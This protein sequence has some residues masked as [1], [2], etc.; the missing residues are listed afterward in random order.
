[1]PS[2]SA[3]PTIRLLTFNTG[4]FR[5]RLGS[6]S[7]LDPIPHAAA[8]THYIADAVRS[9]NPDVI[10][11]QE[12]FADRDL[13]R[14]RSELGG[15]FPYYAAS[16]DYVRAPRIRS[17]SGLCIFSRYPLGD[18]H[19]EVYREAALDE[20]LFVGKGVLRATI[21]SPLGPISLATTHLMS[22]GLFRNPAAPH[23]VNTRQGQIEQLANAGH[24]SPH[25][26][27][28]VVGDMNAG[29]EISAQNYERM[30]EL[31]YIDCWKLHP[32]TEPR[33]KEVTWELANP[34]TGRELHKTDAPQR[35]DHVFVN[36]Q[37]LEH[38][39]IRKAIVVLHEPRV[40]TPAGFVTVSDHYGLLVEIEQ[41]QG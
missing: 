27:R 18:Q 36:E 13:D 30:C 35:I 32:G 29:P 7:I 15:E 14:L 28:L 19:H 16:R 25:A 23:L 2:M 39:T 8:R 21:D 3:T 40:P 34:L 17:H 4:L 22:G 24:A 33:F 37:A 20:W 5:L 41:K 38:V 26:I 9:V 1:M 12:V 11:F 6:W 31:G 10:A